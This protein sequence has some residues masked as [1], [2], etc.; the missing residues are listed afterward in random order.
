[1]SRHVYVYAVYYLD[2]FFMK[3]NKVDDLDEY[4]DLAFGALMTAFKFA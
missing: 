4:Q 3:K 1:V 2:L